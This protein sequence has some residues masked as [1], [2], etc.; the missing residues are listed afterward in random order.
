MWKLC[1]GRSRNRGVGSANRGRDRKSVRFRGLRA[2]QKPLESSFPQLHR[3][4]ATLLS[5]VSLANESYN[6]ISAVRNL[7]AF[8]CS[9][10]EE[11]I[12]S[13]SASEVRTYLVELRFV[14]L[15]RIT[16]QTLFLHL[17]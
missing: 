1:R 6:G 12:I 16:K 3:G 11:F 4:P 14:K 9:G 7:G 8:I 15:S 2:S 13:I 17:T 10:G 5:A